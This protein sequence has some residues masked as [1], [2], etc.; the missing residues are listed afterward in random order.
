LGSVGVNHFNEV[1]W[2]LTNI[3]VPDSERER[4]RCSQHVHT[5]AA[6]QLVDRCAAQSNDTSSRVTRQGQCMKIHRSLWQPVTLGTSPAVALH[7]RH[8]YYGYML[9]PLMLRYPP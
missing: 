7:H 4:T 5:A 1:A 2:G 3:S 6:V 9:S 8:P